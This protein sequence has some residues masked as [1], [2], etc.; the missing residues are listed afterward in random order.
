MLSRLSRSTPHKATLAGRVI[1]AMETE[2]EVHSS[3]PSTKRARL[4]PWAMTSSDGL[5]VAAGSSEGAPT[6]FENQEEQ[7]GPDSIR[8]LPDGVLGEIISRLSTKEGVGTQILARRWRPVCP[9]VPLNLDCRETLSLV[10]LT[11]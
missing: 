9:T 11:I 2:M 7:S 3:G 1:P 4:A 6:G 8:D 5:E 10:F